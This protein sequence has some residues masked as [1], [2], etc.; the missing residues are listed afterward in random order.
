MADEG[1]APAETGGEQK[2]LDDIG[3]P[4][5]LRDQAKLMYLVSMFLGFWGPILFGFV[6]KKEGQDENAWYQAQV[7]NCWFVFVGGCLCWLPGLWM[8]WQ[9]FSAIGDNK[10][11]H[12]PFASPNGFEG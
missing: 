5:E 4:Q 9:G 1:N 10:D 12:I 3:V 11:P 8:G 2:S 6:I 7:R